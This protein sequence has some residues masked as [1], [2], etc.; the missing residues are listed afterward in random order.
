MAL[1]PRDEIHRKQIAAG[2]KGRNK[3]HKIEKIVTMSI[4][5][6][7]VDELSPVGSTSKHIFEGNPAKLVLEYV[8]PRL[9]YKW[10]AQ[11][12]WEA[13]WLGGLA[14]S[15]KGAVLLD[16]AGAKIKKSKS[17]I[18]I[19]FSTP[20]EKDLKI[21]VS[22]KTC[23]KPTPTNA[24]LFFTTA[25]AFCE[26]LR[27]NSI[28]VSEPAEHGMKMFCGD[29]GFRPSDTLSQAAL[30]KRGS[31]RERWFWE[32]LPSKAKTEL[33]GLFS[34]R[35][36][37][38]TEILLRL[39]Y[40]G[41]PFPPDFVMHQTKG[42]N[43][44]ESCEI[45]IYSIAEIVRLSKK[46]SGFHTRP[47]FIRKGSNKGDKNEHLAPRFGIVQMQRGGQKQHPTQLQFNLKA[48]YFYELESLE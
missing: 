24:Q 12:K 10:T 31:D 32:E 41:D 43:D 9:P 33:E 8:L 17:D 42:S 29:N 46:F 35:Q 30:T 37:Q 11:T 20:N 14:T 4:N 16:E 19:F 38:I 28:E 18:V 27:Q 6:M 15:N 44:F 36:N 13:K 5:S 34:D 25:S 40:K 2:T 45:A 23:S 26:L 7:A 21:G 1:Q 47:Y 48:G 39:A 3:G 22:I